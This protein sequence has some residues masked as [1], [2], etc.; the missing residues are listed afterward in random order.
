VY[1]DRE[2]ENPEEEEA[3]W[4]LALSGSGPGGRV[5]YEVEGTMVQHGGCKGGDQWVGLHV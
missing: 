1:W 5:G 4:Q 2:T 3:T